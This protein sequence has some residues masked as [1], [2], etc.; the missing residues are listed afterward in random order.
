M[1]QT[2][3][4]LFDHTS[5]IILSSFIMGLA[6]WGLFIFNMRVTTDY[7]LFVFSCSLAMCS[8]MLATLA[9]RCLQRKIPTEDFVAVSR[10]KF[11]FFKIIVGLVYCLWVA[12]QIVV[13]FLV[14]TSSFRAI[15][16]QICMIVMAIALSV[17]VSLMHFKLLE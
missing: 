17:M 8:A 13:F 16:F 3:L 12:F 4:E 2:D 10:R 14:S 15:I 1:P 7:F 5:L 11:L 6:G 9:V